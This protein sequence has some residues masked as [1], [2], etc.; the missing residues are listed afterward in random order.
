MSP[1]ATVRACLQAYVDK[2]R[3]AIE[4]QEDTNRT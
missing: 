4:A 3:V 1:V 2:D